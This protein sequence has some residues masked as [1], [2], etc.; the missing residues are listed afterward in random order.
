MLFTRVHALPALSEADLAAVVEDT[1]TEDCQSGI[2]VLEKGVRRVP[3]AEVTVTELADELEADAACTGAAFERVLSSEV[4]RASTA[5]PDETLAQ[6]RRELA[7][8]QAD[9]VAV[10]T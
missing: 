6:L 4:G 2:D 10:T 9:L 7:A 5:S 8:A 1:R 3:G